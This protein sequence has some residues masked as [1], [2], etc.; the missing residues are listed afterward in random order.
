MM[1]IGILMIV[2][3]LLIGNWV[4]N[5]N[6]KEAWERPGIFNTKLSGCVINTI[7]IALIIGGIYILMTLS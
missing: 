6:Q 7:P 2:L 4:N 1:I 3:G 5:N